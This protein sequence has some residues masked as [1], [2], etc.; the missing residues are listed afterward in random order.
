M[1]WYD[2]EDKIETLVP[3]VQSTQF[4]TARKGWLVPGDPGI[5]RTL[6]PTDYKEISPRL[7]LAYSPNSSSGFLRKLPAAPGTTP[8]RAPSEIYYPGSVARA[9][10][11]PDAP[12][13]SGSRFLPPQPPP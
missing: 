7:G 13:R 9:L 1:P 12:A 3:G 6:A 4:P 10:F 8:I 11:P 5:P 2:N